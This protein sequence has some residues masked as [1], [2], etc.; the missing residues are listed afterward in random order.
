M[1]HSMADI[2]WLDLPALLLSREFLKQ[3]KQLIENELLSWRLLSEVFIAFTSFSCK[4][5]LN[6]TFPRHYLHLSTG[7]ETTEQSSASF[8][9]AG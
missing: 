7:P 8:D 2:N 9:P 1:L 4:L 6:E 5:N 3:E